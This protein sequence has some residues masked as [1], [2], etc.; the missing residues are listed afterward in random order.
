MAIHVSLLVEAFAKLVGAGRFELPT[1]GPP[2]R[3]SS[4]CILFPF[5]W[6][7]L[8]SFPTLRDLFRDFCS[9]SKQTISQPEWHVR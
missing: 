3:Y 6:S 1:P 4:A 2:D 7:S 8:L 5:N 9:V